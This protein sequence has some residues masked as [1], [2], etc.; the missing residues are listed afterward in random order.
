MII[1]D[2]FRIEQPR[3]EVWDFF[4]D[5]P[6]VSQCVPGATGVREVSTDRYS[7]SLRVRVGPIA[8]N[9][10]GEVT[11]EETEPPRRLLASVDGKD[12]RTSSFIKGTFSA[13]LDAV[14][15]DT[16]EVS[17]E[18][19][20]AIRGRL[21]QFGS[22]VMQATAK[23]MT[24]AFVDCTRQE[25]EAPSQADPT[26]ERRDTDQPGAQQ[27]SLLTIILRTMRRLLGDLWRRLHPR[28]T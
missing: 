10:E 17:Y 19:D 6:R 9:F 1:A 8:A 16:T 27:V 2:K 18:V 20:V 7:G 26:G 5:I 28:S 13:T 22:T 12:R 21:G 24:L 14:T 11:V 23:E 25:L 15:P 4:L 3:A